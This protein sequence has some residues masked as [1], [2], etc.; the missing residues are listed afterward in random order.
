[1]YKINEIF[2]SISGEANGHFQGRITTFIRFS[3][4]NL[5]CSYCD[6]KHKKHQILSSS[7]IIAKMALTEPSYICLTGGEPL[8]QPDI[9]ILMKKLC[10]EGHKLSVETNGTVDITPYFRFIDSFVIDYKLEYPDKMIMSNFELLRDS[11][12][13]KF[14]VKDSEQFLVALRIAEEFY[15]MGSKNIAFSPIKGFEET[16]AKALIS[17]RVPYAIYSVQLHKILGLR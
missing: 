1:M 16:L 15:K 13:I 11:D 5:K 6:T 10:S 9:D 2:T 4:C 17:F 3:G 12:I 7:S 14:V 8:I